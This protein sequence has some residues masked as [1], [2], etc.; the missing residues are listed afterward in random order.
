LASAILVSGL[1]DLEAIP[2]GPP[3]RAYFGA[4]AASAEVSSQPELLATPVP[5]LLAYGELDLRR[6]SRRH[7]A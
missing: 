1:Y 6:S 5:P 4:K 2:P 7:D 3:E